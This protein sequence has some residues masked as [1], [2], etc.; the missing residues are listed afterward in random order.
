MEEARLRWKQHSGTE[1]PIDEARLR[2]LLRNT[3]ERLFLRLF[4][5][6]HGRLREG[7]KALLQGE[8]DVGEGLTGH[9]NRLPQLCGPGFLDLLR[10]QQ[11]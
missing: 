2:R 7:G 11:P 6:D 5:V 10:L 4:G 8:G 9:R 3:E 1:E